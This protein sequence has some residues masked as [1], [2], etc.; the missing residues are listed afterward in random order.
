[1]LLRNFN[2]L[3]R[4]A[5]APPVDGAPATRS[6]SVFANREGAAWVG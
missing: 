2:T 3:R 5:E 1:V 6:E 4:V